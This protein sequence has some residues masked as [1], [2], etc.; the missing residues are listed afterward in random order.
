M[1]C[2]YKIKTEF[3]ESD[4]KD[5]LVRL[6]SISIT[7]F[8]NVKKGQLSFTNNRKSFKTSILGLYGQNGSGKTALI[9][10][11]ALLQIALRSQQIPQYFA[12]SLMLKQ[13][14]QFFNMS[15]MFTMSFRNIV[16]S[17]NSN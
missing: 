7:N 12:E 8:K 16:L 17:M 9:D 1:E 4:M 13:N 5:M 3:W 10:A 14:I 15:S 6:E 2:Y 11:I